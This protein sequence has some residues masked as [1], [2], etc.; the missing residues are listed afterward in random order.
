[1][2]YSR[3]SDATGRYQITHLA[4]HPKSGGAGGITH[5]NFFFLS[6]DDRLIHRSKT[7]LL[8]SGAFGNVHA[9]FTFFY[10]PDYRR[11][12]NTIEVRSYLSNAAFETPVEEDTVI[13]VAEA[14]LT[15]IS[16]VRVFRHTPEFLVISADYTPAGGLSAF[17]VNATAGGVWTNAPGA[18]GR[19]DIDVGTTS[20]GDRSPLRRAFGF[21]AA[22]RRSRLRD[23]RPCARAPECAGAVPAATADIGSARAG[24]PT[25]SRCL[26]S[27]TRP[28]TVTVSRRSVPSSSCRPSGDS[29]PRRARPACD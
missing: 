27:S 15:A 22:H 7:Q 3:F 25:S 21:P 10:A 23:H 5:H 14:S 1:M 4:R 11:D 6:G 16:L 13:P 28:I 24:S 9:I 17:H 18:S 29:D 2:C 8:F 19:S 26:A 12:P 20:V